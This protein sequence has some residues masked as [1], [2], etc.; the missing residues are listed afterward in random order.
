MKPSLLSLC[1]TLGLLL[2]ACGQNGEAKSQTTTQSTVSHSTQSATPTPTTDA[3]YQSIHTALQNNLTQSGINAHVTTVTPVDMPDMYLAQID[4]MPPV[5]TDKTGT[6]IFQGDLIKLSDGQAVNLS[7][8]AQ[9]AAAKHALS[10]VPKSQMIVFPA[11]GETKAAIYVFSD[12]T[13]HY[14]QLLHK[15]VEKT[16]AQGIEVRYLAWPR[17][18]QTIPLTESIWCSDDRARALTDAKHG[19]SIP[20]KTCDNPVKE[21]IA[22]GYALGVSGTPAVFSESGR[23]L[24]GYLPSEQLAQ[25]AIANK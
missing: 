10:A 11:K 15:E 8:S 2:S 17:G 16:N 9:A 25:S 5:F 19:K 24:G 20:P 18:E 7:E 12:P 22:L 1:L 13:C 3:Q 23:Q 4:G 14:C 6:Y 21:H